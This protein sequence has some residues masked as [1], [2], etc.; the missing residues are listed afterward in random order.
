MR[1][2]A[3]ALSGLTLIVAIAAAARDTSEPTLGPRLKPC[4]Q[5]RTKVAAMCGAFGVYEGREMHAGVDP[6]P[7][8]FNNPVRSDVPI[9]MLEGSDDPATPPKYAERAV[10]TLPNAKLVLV[11][12]AGHGVVTPCTNRL[13]IQFIREG[14]AAHIAA[15]SCNAAFKAPPFETSMAKWDF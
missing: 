10:A 11:R 8:A 3:V 15:A 6:M 12:G 13:D 7:A 14:S 1:T 4:R 9:L 5:G 2:I